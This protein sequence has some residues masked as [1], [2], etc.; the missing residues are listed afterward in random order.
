MFTTRKPTGLM[1]AATF[2]AMA[3]GSSLAAAQPL[4]KDLGSYFVFAMRNASLKNLDLLSACNVGVNCARPTTNSSCGVSTVENSFFADGSQLAADVTRFNRGGASIFQLFSNLMPNT[5]NV[6]VR[7]PGPG[8]GGATPLT[9][10]IIGDLDGDGRASCS[11]GCTPDYEDLAVFC[12]MPS[13]APVCDVTKP[14]L[15]RT[16]GDCTG[17]VD[18][19]PSNARCDLP[20]GAYGSLTV[21]NGAAIS[22][23]GGTYTFCSVGMGRNVNAVVKNAATLNV[24]G[25]FSVN[26]GSTF[27]Q[28]CGDLNVNAFGPGAVGFGRNS[29]VT[30]FFCAPER[31]VNLGHN[32]DLTGRFVGDVVNA[33]SN[34]RGRCCGSACAC[35]DDVTPR[36]AGVGASVTLTGGCSLANVGGVRICG[37]TAPITFRSTD[38]IVVTVPA[39]A[40]GE[41]T[42]EVDSGAGTFTLLRTLRVS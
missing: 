10:P 7:R 19:Q 28:Q 34:N 38:E 4:R 22:Y 21:Q 20:A 25:D 2:G 32:N 14:V 17:A 24:T 13:P 35:V 41:C 1:L 36:T 15:V 40:T 11:A 5:A 3:L 33:D 29:S 31:T 37:R 9:L 8:P 18:S 30:G 16:G 26:N 23:D 42:V 39:G 6:T 27:G 12:G